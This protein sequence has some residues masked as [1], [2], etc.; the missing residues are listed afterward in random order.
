VKGV[1]GSLEV[2]D[3]RTVAEATTFVLTLK[4]TRGEP[5]V[6]TWNDEVQLVR[7]KHADNKE[8]IADVE[9]RI[10]REAT[11]KLAGDL[12][13]RDLD[14]RL[15]SVVTKR[16]ANCLARAQLLYAI[17]T[18]LGI[19]AK[20]FSIRES[21][22]DIV[23]GGLAHVETLFVLSNGKTAMTALS[24]YGMVTRQFD[25]ETSY[26][27]DPNSGAV[28][29][30]KS[31]AVFAPMIGQHKIRR[32][33]P[34]DQRDLIA[35]LYNSRGE[36]RASAGDL[37]RAISDFD[38][39]IEISPA[40]FIAYLSRGV[41]FFRKG[42]LDRASS[43]Y[44]EAIRLDPEYTN[45]YFGR[46]LIRERRG[47]LSGAISDCTKAQEL[48]PRWT[49]PYFRRG[50]LFF[51]QGKFDRA[52]ADFTRAI[53]LDPNQRDPNFAAAIGNRGAAL[54][55]NGNQT[56]AVAD[57]KRAVALDPRDANANHNLRIAL[58]QNGSPSDVV[59]TK[60]SNKRHTP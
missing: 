46:C 12:L 30:L 25:L 6:S 51:G 47:D 3:E 20:V 28:W 29:T 59:G 44:D 26:A 49:Q 34:F 27:R 53:Q 7:S 10:V 11:A 54:L 31:G 4:N 60:P 2:Y 13:H 21:W 40:C 24:Q 58:S 33:A 9:Y 52:I 15:S 32:F 23:V 55:K 38:R 1:V 48:S 19:A 43:D 18:S 5:A 8:M 41:A 35:S 45:A 50:N 37:D 57:L 39:A 16:E 42:Q 22:D 36:D 56:D 14:W 17:A